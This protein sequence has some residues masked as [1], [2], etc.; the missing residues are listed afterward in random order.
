[1]NAIPSTVRVEKGPTILLGSGTYFDYEAPEK[2][3]ITIEDYAYGLAFECRFRG[4]CVS[5]ATGKR[6]YYSVAQHAV[7]CSYNMPM[8]AAMPSWANYDH[9]AFEALMHESGEP[10]CGDMVAPLK[11]INPDFKVIEKR[12]ESAIGRR[13]GVKGDMHDAVKQVDLRMWATE[14]RDLMN[15]DGV[16]WGGDGGGVA[17]GFGDAPSSP[18]K[19]FEFT[20]EP[21]QD[22]HACAELFLNRWREL[23]GPERFAAAQAA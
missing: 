23:G 4:Q 19:P 6:V 11:T 20:I 22:P 13:F 1:M 2:S 17:G 10:V 5:R 9:D 18:V 7:L 15:W 21:I 8:N 12:C 16:P 3:L 14:R